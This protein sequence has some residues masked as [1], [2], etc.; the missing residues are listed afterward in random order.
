MLNARVMCPPKLGSQCA[1]RALAVA[2]ATT[3]KELEL[4]WAESTAYKLREQ[5]SALAD[6]LSGLRGS[7]R[8]R[9]VDVAKLPTDNIE[10]V[11]LR[12]RALACAA[13]RA[14]VAEE[15]KRG[16]SGAPTS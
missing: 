5:L 8:R 15:N 1:F 10:D 6:S 9:D 2:L 3:S 13:L 16:P 4:D 14:G 11:A 7:V 12:L